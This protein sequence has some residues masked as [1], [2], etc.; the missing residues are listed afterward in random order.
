MAH[1]IHTS[2]DEAFEKIKPERSTY[3]VIVTRGHKDDIASWHGRS[4]PK[5]TS[6]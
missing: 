5:P 1:E 3:I 2:F 6:G 4:Q